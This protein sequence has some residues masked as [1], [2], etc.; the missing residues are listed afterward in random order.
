MH[1][2]GLL[3]MGYVFAMIAVLFWGMSFISTS[4]LLEVFA[5]LEILI[6][7]FIMAYL[8]LWLF[9]PHFVK[10]KSVKDE[11]MVAA[12]GLSGIVLYYVFETVALTY[13]RTSNVG[14]ITALATVFT[15]I[16]CSIGVKEE[17]L[18]VR[19]FGGF[20]IALAGI[21]LISYSGS[22]EFSMNPLGD[23]LALLSAI[24]WGIYSLFVRFLLQ[25][26]DSVVITRRVFFY[27]IIFLFLLTPFMKFSWDLTRFNGKYL[28]NIIVL[29]LGASALS[30]ASWNQAI[31]KL[32][33]VKS[34][35]FIY[36]MPV[37]TVFG[38]WIVLGEVPSLMS[39]GGVLLVMAGLVV[40]ERKKNKRKKRPNSY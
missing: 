1:K 40:S 32:G 7:R 13:T 19:F 6:Y 34:A 35:V 24:S 14:V 22:T 5:P 9:R 21:I 10:F 16:F 25:K 17:K 11:L 4:I 2:D 23:F 12:A 30:M 28:F 31:L 3:I 36:L 15:A 38:A 33:A 20:A 8:A 26:Y 29:G 18:S 39:G 37:I 27:G